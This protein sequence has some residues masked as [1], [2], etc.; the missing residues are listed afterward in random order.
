MWFPC[1][2][3][4]LLIVVFL[5]RCWGRGGSLSYRAESD[6]DEQTCSISEL[7][8]PRLPPLCVGFARRG[9]RSGSSKSAS[10][11]IWLS[12][13]ASI[14]AR[15][16]CN[17]LL[18]VFVVI[19]S[20]SLAPLSSTARRPRLPAERVR[21]SLRSSSSS[22]GRCHPFCRSQ[23]NRRREQ[24]PTH[25]STT[26]TSVANAAILPTGPAAN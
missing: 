5:V 20:I 11:L 26:A 19:S 14:T 17:L 13:S 23:C 12:S 25:S 4:C 22:Y 6:S 10:M 8:R 7:R 24:P 15:R 9:S 3:P 18:R 1:L 21:F 2:V 16:P